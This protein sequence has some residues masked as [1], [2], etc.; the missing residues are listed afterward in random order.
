MGDD[1]AAG[2]RGA[3]RSDHDGSPVT[4]PSPAA[5]GL[6][7]LLVVAVTFAT[8]AVGFALPH[9]GARLA[10]P[11]L[12]SGVAVGALVR[13]GR[14]LWPAVFAAEFAIEL[15]NGTPVLAGLVV[16]A[17]LP[18]GAW[19][20]AW[21]LERRHFDPTFARARD[22][23]LFLGATVVGM[24]LSATIG[25]LGLYLNPLLAGPAASPSTGCAGGATRA[26]ACCSSRRC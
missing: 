9:W 26:P 23:P 17:G 10:L 5:R 12:P 13:F 19:V 11:L 3:D 1:R 21:L 22:V 8:G 18:A 24:A 6:R 20:T 16:A 2:G 15:W 7:A 25:L 14:G 4:G